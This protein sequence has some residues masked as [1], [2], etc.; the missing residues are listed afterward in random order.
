MQIKKFL[1]P[2]CFLSIIV[3]AS[4]SV[5]KEAASKSAPEDPNKILNQKAFDDAFYEGNKQMVLGNHMDA[6]KKFREC[7]SLDSKNPTAYYLLAKEY[8]LLRQ[9]DASYMYA[10]EAVK[11]KSDEIW[12]RLMEAEDLVHINKNTD[13]AK[14]YE[15]IG[16]KFSTFDVY[17]FD[18]AEQFMVAGKANDALRVLDKLEKKR[19]VSEEVSYKKEDIYIRQNKKDLAVAEL[20]K[21]IKTYPEIKRYK[22]ALAEVYYG[23][24]D[25]P[26]AMEILSEVLHG[27]PGMPEA[28][29][30]LANIYRNQGNN[31]KSFD[32]LRIVFANPDADVKQKLQ[33]LSSYL[34]LIS[35]N[36][37]LRSQALA[38]GDLLTT[39]H[40]ND[41][42]CNM[43]YGDILFTA[44]R[45]ADAKRYY[46]KALQ[47]NS[48]NAALW[49]NLIQCEDQL[50]QT[51]SALIH[52]SEAL[53]AYPGKVIF[54]YYKAF[55]SFRLKDYETA[56]STAKAG[57]DLG[58]E[59]TRVLIQLLSIEGD[60]Q[61]AL[62]HYKESDA[63]YEKILEMDPNN[64]QTLNN[65]AYYLS[66]RKDK[67]D[68]A[69]AMSKK[70]LELDPGNSSYLDT[71]GWI[72]YREM[73]YTEAR[74]YIEKALEMQPDNT[75]LNEHL[76]DIYYRLN[77]IEKAM[78]YWKK[79]QEHGN[80]ST[81]LAQKIN[82]KKLGDQD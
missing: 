32:E 68:R 1:F 31:D 57:Y 47:S 46:S 61:N 28:H 50:K 40:P 45:F 63:A 18:A 38:L 70:T 71:Y 30:L 13:A 4:C 80:S 79:S 26:K 11:L 59:N 19:G 41:P 64:L 42:S 9:Y 67:L 3:L 24:K 55:Y 29:M 81:A 78:L 27:D 62:K 82:N 75:V 15:S 58:S 8:S 12:F 2:V 49:E 6:V 66:L 56:A 33:V 36:E 77:N 25:E 74:D 44:E 76:G 48:A 7:I 53:E 39:A 5:K 52:A 21:L 20:L 34:P 73:K 17:Y 54:Y 10:K 65:Y 51:D 16:D 60:A 14:A 23:F 43:I 69:E 72:L 35:G 22:V 37:K